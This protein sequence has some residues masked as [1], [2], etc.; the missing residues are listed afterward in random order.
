VHL[1]Q[2]LVVREVEHTD[3]HVAEMLAQ[4]LGDFRIGLSG[5]RFQ[6]LGLR[7]CREAPDI[8][9]LCHNRSQSPRVGSTLACLD[10][11]AKHSNLQLTLLEASPRWRVFRMAELLSEAARR[12]LPV[13]LPGWA[14]VE[15]RDVLQ[16][17]F[18]FRTFSEAWGF[19]TRVA[20]AAEKLN[21]HPEWS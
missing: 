11:Q 12:A 5:Q 17:S 18:K 3:D 9:H 10:R 1:L 16:K 13:E 4:L 6:V 2:R 19:M 8:V 14:P 20:L 15:G 21:H 7:R